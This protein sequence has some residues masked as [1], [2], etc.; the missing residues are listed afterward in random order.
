FALIVKF[1]PPVVTGTVIT[2]I[3]LSLMP[4]AAG[5]AMG[6]D[7]TAADYGSIRNILITVATLAVVLILSRIPSAMVARRSILAAFV[8][9]TIGCLIFGWAYCSHVPARRIFA[10]PEPCA[11]GM[12]TFSAA[13]FISMFIVVI[14]PSAETSAD[15]I[16]V[17][18][19]ART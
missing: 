14:V 18:E 13:A 17:C 6:G 11:F 5:W 4:V 3:G 10:F 8:I 2:T 12:P 1:F 9:G 7:E 19:I 16:A 15:I